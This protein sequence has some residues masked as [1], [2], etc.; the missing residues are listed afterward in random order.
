[1]EFSADPVQVVFHE[2]GSLTPEDRILLSERF[3]DCRFLDREC[4]DDV[5]TSRLSAYPHAL[6]F[7]QASVWGLKL[8][9]IVLAEPGFCF[10]I[11]S[12][13]RF[14]RPFQGLFT[15]EATVGRTVF[16]RD[17]VWQAYSIR[18]WHLL[19]GGLQVASGINTGLTL[20]DPAV[21]DL[22]YV[23]WFLGHVD[24]G[25]IPAWIEPT[26]WAALA[27]RTNGH[28]VDPEQLVN[29][30][31][32]AKITNQTVGGH[33]LSSYRMQWNDLLTK[34]LSGH[35]SNPQTIRFIPLQPLDPLALGINQVKRKLQNTF[36]RIPFGFG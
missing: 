22:D 13:I 19:T 5:M 26:C 8:L 10:Y 35:I 18:P 15:E 29:L 12:D 20:V 30:Y 23:D 11:D 32:A 21:F 6:A 2:D 33:F 36:T 3:P 9:D 17:S 25:V 14:F 4:T 7:R 31:P 1:M 27:L 24:W 16:L 28:A 34:P